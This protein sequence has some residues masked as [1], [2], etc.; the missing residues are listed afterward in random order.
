MTPKSI[1]FTL[2][3]WYLNQR[4]HLLVAAHLKLADLTLV[5][6]FWFFVAKLHLYQCWKN[7]KNFLIK[8]EAKNNQHCLK[9]DSGISLQYWFNCQ[10]KL[11]C[12][13]NIF[14]LYSKNRKRKVNCYR[15][16]LDN[17]VLCTHLQKFKSPFLET[18][19]TS[20][21]EFFLKTCTC[22]I[23]S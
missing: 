19:C 20:I 10:Q 2:L 13:W 1:T 9:H 8:Q 5:L 4:L 6:L 12:N 17:I 11:G 21:F 22:F 23:N 18:L 14:I 7:E 16:I 15:N 3:V